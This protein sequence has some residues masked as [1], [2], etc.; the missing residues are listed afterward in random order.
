MCKDFSESRLSRLLAEAAAWSDEQ[1]ANTY[2]R[3]IPQCDPFDV[4]SARDRGYLALRSAVDVQKL[5]ISRYAVFDLIQSDGGC[6]DCVL[7]EC[8]F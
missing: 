6:V 5:S 8:P 4:S 3:F 1:F 7:I 2:V